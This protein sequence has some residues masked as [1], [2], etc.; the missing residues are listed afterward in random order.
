[1]T[2]LESGNFLTGWVFVVFISEERLIL[3]NKKQ[4]LINK[5]TKRVFDSEKSIGY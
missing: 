3:C 2:I 5:L 4:Y 1:M